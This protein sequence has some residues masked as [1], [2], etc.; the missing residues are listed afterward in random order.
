MST[1]RRTLLK[2][3]LGAT[4]LGLIEGLGI[5]GSRRAWADN[6]TRRPTKLLTLYV[7]GGW[8]PQFVFSPVRLDEVDSRLTPMTLAIGGGEPASYLRR[9]VEKNLD[10]TPAGDTPWAFRPLRMPRQWDETELAAGRKD[11]RLTDAF[12]SRTSP[13]GW[14]WVHYELWKNASVVHGV[15]QGTASHEGGIISTLCG[16]AGAEFASPAIHALVA[17]AMLTRFPDR[18]LPY[19]GLGGPL[20]PSLKL[21]AKSAAIVMSSASSAQTLLSER[22]SQ[23][24]GLK[25]RTLK[26]QVAFDGSAAPDL[27]TTPLEDFLLAR[28]RRI[29]AKTNATTDGFYQQL[30]DGYVNY[31]QT[32]AR[33][34]VTL[35]EKTP[36]FEHINQPGSLFPHWSTNGFLGY[37]LGS[38][39]DTNCG[40]LLTSM[41]LALK[42][43]K[44]NLTSAISLRVDNGYYFDSHSDT[45]NAHYP[46][47]RAMLDVIGRFLGEMKNTPATGGGSLLDD[48]VVMICS[49]F[50]RTWNRGPGTDHWPT[51][52]VVF[53]GG[54]SSG[55][56]WLQ[57]NRMIGGF[58]VAGTTPSFGGQPIDLIDEHGQP[59]NRPPQSRDVVFSALDMM[60]IKVFLQGGPGRIVGLGA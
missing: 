22:G 57:N 7:P 49:E 9:H 15:D 34:V 17:N 12:G 44:S 1:S 25:T 24:T 31:S 5:L 46:Q 28:T 37:S 27:A 35:L 54:G 10:G 55:A 8:V 50:G 21:G 51:T 45:E 18:A 39:I 47:L 40:G 6:V 60:G 48:T 43:L 53:A 3:A 19:V 32:L 20:G 56:G 4:Q 36:G 33:D 13:H 42:L 29:H 52:S 41:D 23:W 26:H 11:R 2:L 58:D 30:Y 59:M 16:I 38:S 14:S